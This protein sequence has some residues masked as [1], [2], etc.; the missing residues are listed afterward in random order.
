MCFNKYIS[1]VNMDVNGDAQM[2]YNDRWG[3]LSQDGCS[4]M[5]YFAGGGQVTSKSKSGDYEIAFNTER[6]VRLAT[7]ALQISIDK[8][9]TLMANPYVA[10]NGNSWAAAT[11]WFSGGGALFRSS[12]LEPIPRDLR[13]LDGLLDSGDVRP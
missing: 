1:D 9:K 7:E 11:A 10:E 4:W 5:M 13:T 3:F 12:V 2:D 8:S 6:N